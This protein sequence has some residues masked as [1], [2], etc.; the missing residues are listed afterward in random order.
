MT[1]YPTLLALHL[2]AAAWWVGGMA[3]IQFAIRPAAA[4]ALPAPPLRL[5]LMAAALGR[6]LRGV[7]GAIAVLFASGL[8]MILGGGGFAAQPWG[9]H[10]MAGIALGMTAL[11]LRIRVALFPRLRRAVAASDW[12]AGGAALNGIRIVVTI[13]LA[14]GV[15]VFVLAVVGR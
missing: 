1:L 11:Y 13:N 12:Q 4:A 14:L 9:V 15:A 8:A 2:L 6:F 10:A 7:D 5:A 3:T